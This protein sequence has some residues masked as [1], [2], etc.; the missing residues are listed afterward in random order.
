[1]SDT[2]SHEPVIF[3]GAAQFKEHVP[4]DVPSGVERVFAA[5]ALV[6]VASTVARTPS[7]Y[8]FSRSTPL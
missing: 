2:P 8:L 4:V 7:Q 1:M 6:V 5:A 3:V